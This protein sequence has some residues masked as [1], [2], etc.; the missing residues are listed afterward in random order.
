MQYLLTKEYYPLDFIL[1]RGLNSRI[2]PIM[3]DSTSKPT[4]IAVTGLVVDIMKDQ[5]NVFESTG[6]IV[7][8]QKSPRT[9][10]I[11]LIIES[12]FKDASG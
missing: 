9:I 10:S 4:L 3:L 1:N 8:I 12:E 6:E 11:S 5:F 7:F 2:D